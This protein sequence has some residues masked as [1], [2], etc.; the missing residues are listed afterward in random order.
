M[1]VLDRRATVVMG[2][3]I[4]FGFAMGAD[5]MLIPLVAADCFGLSSLGKILALIIMSDSLGQT[6]GPVMAGRIFDTWHSYNLAWF[7]ASGAGILGASAVYLI[8]TNKMG[9]KPP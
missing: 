6:F 4:L 5:F 3:A 7:I 1:L 9:K 8:R 2:F